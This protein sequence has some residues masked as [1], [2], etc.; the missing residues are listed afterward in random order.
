[1][2]YTINLVAET[3]DVIE[4]VDAPDRLEP[5]WMATGLDVLDAQG[6]EVGE[7]ELQ[8]SYALKNLHGAPDYYRMFE[9]SPGDYHEVESVLERLLE[10]ARDDPALKME[11]VY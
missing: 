1:M 5:I 10:V 6:L 2:A 9:L 4:T 7:Y 8:V 11:V 3:G